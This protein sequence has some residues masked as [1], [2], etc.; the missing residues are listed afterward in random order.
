MSRP[1][2]AQRDTLACEVHRHAA[3]CTCETVSVIAATV[4]RKS[5]SAS[6]LGS[7]V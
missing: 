7:T 2:A 6:D 3:I 1:R 5:A 4:A